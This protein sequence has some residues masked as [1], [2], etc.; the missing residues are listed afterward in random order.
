MNELIGKV[1]W[2][3]FDLPSH[4]WP[5]PGFPAYVVVQGVDMPMVKLCSRWGGQAVWVN[6]SIIKKISAMPDQPEG[7]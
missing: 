5:M 3:D 6:A 2:C 1:C 7:E 4:D